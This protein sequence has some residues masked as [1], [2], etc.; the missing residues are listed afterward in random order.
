MKYK[1]L[2][3]I[4]DRFCL[5][6]KTCCCSLMDRRHSSAH[7]M[8]TCTLINY[9]QCTHKN[10]WI[11]IYIKYIYINIYTYKNKHTT[12]I[13]TKQIHR[14]PSD[15]RCKII[16]KREFRSPVDILL[17]EQMHTWFTHTQLIFCIQILKLTFL[18]TY[19]FM[20]ASLLGAPMDKQIK[21]LENSRSLFR[22]PLWYN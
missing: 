17:N 8:H 1:V 4:E 14:W 19:Y 22:K 16:K 13:I 9:A 11:Q 20:F 15:L 7:F 18:T 2:W 3:W 10:T 5:Y 21:Y 6:E 12:Q